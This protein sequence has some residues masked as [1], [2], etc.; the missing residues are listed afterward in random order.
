MGPAEAGGLSAEEA[1]HRLG[2]KRETLY[3]Y[4]SRGLLTSRRVAG[5]RRSRFDDAEVRRL[6]ERRRA[7]GRAGSLELVVDSGLTLLDPSGRLWFRGWDVADACRRATFEEVAEWLWGT[8]GGAPFVAT[9]EALAAARVAEEALPDGTR[10]A[11][12]LPVVVAAAAA[13]DP[14]RFDRRRD[15]VAATGRRIIGVVVDALP[16]VSPATAGRA[17][18]SPETTA[19]A[20]R[21]MA[22]LCPDPEQQTEPRRRVLEAALVLLADHEMASST[23][24]ARVAASTWADPYQVV[25]AGLAALGGP[26]HGGVGDRLV[27]LVQD[28]LDGGAAFAVGDRLRAGEQI[29]GFGHSVYSGRDPRADALLPMLGDAWPGHPVLAAV[30]EL[31]DVVAGGGDTFPNVDL[32]LAALVSCAGM[33]PGSAAAI[34][35]VARCAG[36]LGH[37]MEEYGHRLRFRIRAAYTGPP[38]VERAGRAP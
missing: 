16:V 22:R 30:E 20:A 2:V 4:V 31:V 26:L 18:R 33:V 15:A 14:L 32:A 36:W 24:A 1:A 5:E 29:A 7:G 38:P 9:D 27:P 12:R 19:V 25:L 10:P 11:D 34:F 28:A 3:A 6:A 23:L 37:A 8:G 21:L 35:A 17:V 13:H